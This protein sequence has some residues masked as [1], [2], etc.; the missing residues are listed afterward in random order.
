MSRLTGAALAILF[1]GAAYTQAAAQSF[2]SAFESEVLV[3][4]DASVSEPQTGSA[5]TADFWHG[6]DGAILGRILGDIRIEALSSTGQQLLKRLLL[7]DNWPMPDELEA[8]RLS[9][10]LQLGALA[11]ISAYPVNRF[12]GADAAQMAESYIIA[13]LLDGGLETACQ[14]RTQLPTVTKPGAIW[15]RLDATCFELAGDALQTELALEVSAANSSPDPIFDGLFIALSTHRL[16]ETVLTAEEAEDVFSRALHFAMLRQAGLDPSIAGAAANQAP[17]RLSLIRASGAPLEL[18]IAAAEQAIIA[19]QILPNELGALFI[20]ANR[21]MNGGKP[22]RIN[23]TLRAA[24]QQHND[25]TNAPAGRDRAA[26]IAIALAH[27]EKRNAFNTTAHLYAD[28]ILG[29]NPTLADEADTAILARALLT[30][31]AFEEAKP[32]F[33]IT[34]QAAREKTPGGFERMSYVWPLI[35]MA[36]AAHAPHG[37][38]KLAG[39]WLSTLKASEDESARHQAVLLLT[40]LEGFNRPADEPLWAQLLP[41]RGQTPAP[42]M[43]DYTLWRGMEAAAAR[44]EQGMALSFLLNGLSQAP[45]NEHHPAYIA[46]AVSV[47]L[48]LG[49]E[50]DGHKLAVDALLAAG[51]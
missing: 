25:V 36:E 34:Y 12:K 51:F 46:S 31:G 48:S 47:L 50:A 33:M 6:A 27:A 16:D 44:G 38:Q 39:G 9:T 26:A 13:H 18:R 42:Y 15:A 29:A 11:E 10:L 3:A 20:T 17:A 5:P 49:L 8:S 2:D 30:I 32:W 24:A 37:I 43:V 1:V 40:L 4:P 14:A 35:A 21:G 7:S 19:G 28:T 23:E 22:P 45:L 41:T